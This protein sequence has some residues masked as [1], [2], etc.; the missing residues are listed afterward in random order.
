V[1]QDENMQMAQN[2]VETEVKG[3]VGGRNH[4]LQHQVLPK[5][6]TKT[7][8]IFNKDHMA[9]EVHVHCILITDDILKA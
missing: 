1:E 4:S 5:D 9:Q 6:K 2:S 7:L 3:M 8:M